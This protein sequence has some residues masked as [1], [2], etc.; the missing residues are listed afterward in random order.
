MK[1]SEV[2]LDCIYDGM[3]YILASVYSGVLAWLVAVVNI[4]ASS[5]VYVRIVPIEKQRNHKQKKCINV[6]SHAVQQHSTFFIQ[7]LFFLLVLVENL[8]L[9]CT[10]LVWKVRKLWH[11]QVSL[12]IFFKTRQNILQ[13]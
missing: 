12:L 11:P 3:T 7:T 13:F 5:L 10:P 4:F 8:M 9:A 6:P 2:M 1:Q